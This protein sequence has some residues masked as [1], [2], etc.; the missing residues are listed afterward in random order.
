VQV[1]QRISEA[2]YCARRRLDNEKPSESGKL[3]HLPPV[4]PIYRPVIPSA[5]KA[6]MSHPGFVGASGGADSKSRIMS[7]A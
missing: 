4:M 6:L 3:Q 2:G 7:L 5:V 1:S